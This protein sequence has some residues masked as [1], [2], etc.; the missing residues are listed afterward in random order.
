M[1]FWTR[2]FG[3]EQKSATLG[4]LHRLN[5]GTGREASSGVIVT[6][7]AALEV[8]TVLACC[9]VISEGVAQVPWHV[10][11][12]KDGRKRIVSG[13]LDNLLYRRP[14][15]WQTSFEFRETLMFHVI[16]TGNAYVFVN[17][18]GPD[19]EITEL[20]PIEPKQVDVKQNRDMSLEYRVT[21]ALTGEQK[22]FAADAIWHLRGPSWNSWLGLDAVKLA[23][24]AI[25]LSSTLEQGQAEFQKNGA[26]SS[27]IL[28]VE[29][30]LSADQYEQLSKWLDRHQ[31]GGDRSGKPL[32]VDRAS[33]FHTLN[34]SSV[35]QQL[36]ETRKHQI[37]EIC[38]EFRV[39][40]QMVG[41]A[42]D[43]TPTFASAEQFF[44][45]HVVHTL[46]PWYQRT[47]QSADVNL[48][49]DDQRRAGFYTKLNPNALMRGAAK[50][51]AEYYAKGLGSGGSKGWLTQNDVRGLEEMELSAEPEA[52]KLPQPIAKPANP[53]EK[54]A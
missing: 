39:F 5:F 8:S 21:S 17:R 44:L 53:S 24:N 35:D 47:E 25:G 23:R 7:Q 3:G 36:L 10:Y 13:G 50:D 46:M 29:G 43:Q 19:R 54:P 15:A 6:T 40:P 52:D 34:A 45:A 14:N 48:L 11:Q 30:N 41:H 49:T 4:E 2:L 26:R 32:I 51:R 37:E 27:G 38:R 28:A 18:V 1:G 31:V 33:K 20:I 22:L 9:R 42:G 12:E 16:L